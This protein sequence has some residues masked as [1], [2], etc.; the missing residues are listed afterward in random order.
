[1]PAWP[2]HKGST[3]EE[4]TPNVVLQL[5]GGQAAALPAAIRGSGSWPGTCGLVSRNMRRW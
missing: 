3:V 5:W 1:M 4:P 2:L